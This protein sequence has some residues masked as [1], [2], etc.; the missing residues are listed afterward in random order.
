MKI[1]IAVH[2]TIIILF[3]TNITMGL[4]IRNNV[5]ETDLHKNFRRSKTSGCS[6]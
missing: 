5:W 2:I 1:E 3:T 6:L 4:L